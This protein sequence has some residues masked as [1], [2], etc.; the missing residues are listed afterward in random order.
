MLR[1]SGVPFDLRMQQPYDAYTS[2]GFN[3]P[4][5]HNGDC[6]DRYFVRVEEMRQSIKII[7]HCI[8]TMSLG[9]IKALN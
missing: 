7:N 8:N 5:G 4:I 9:P 1:G 2:V 6:F 3:V